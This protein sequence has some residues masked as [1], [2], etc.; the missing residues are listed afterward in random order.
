MSSTFNPLYK[1]VRQLGLPYQI[2]E[3]AA[4]I[5]I[6]I[7]SKTQQHQF[8]NSR[9]KF[10]FHTTRTY[11]GSNNPNWRSPLNFEENLILLRTS[12]PDISFFQSTPP[13]SHRV[14][15]P[16]PPA[17]T[18]PPS[19]TPTTAPAV[20]PAD[21]DPNQTMKIGNHSLDN[22]SQPQTETQHKELLL[23]PLDAQGA[24]FTFLEHLTS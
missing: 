15:P 23:I 9:E 13:P 2:K 20:L 6:K 8:N 4:S 22:S 14:T 12:F 19:S 7:S 24:I 16:P 3:S 10:R 1:Q 21:Q 11:N 18:C 5:I 17:S